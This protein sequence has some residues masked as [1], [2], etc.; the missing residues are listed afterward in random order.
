MKV[1]SELFLWIG[2][3]S[4][5]IAKLIS[6][7][8]AYNYM[9]YF[10]EQFIKANVSEFEFEVDGKTHVVTPLEIVMTRKDVNQ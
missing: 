7:S 8:T 4:F 10:T 6:P 3:G 5:Y 2:M 1:L 9:G